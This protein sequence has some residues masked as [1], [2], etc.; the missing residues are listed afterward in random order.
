MRPISSL[1]H[2][3]RFVHC[4]LKLM[5]YLCK[6]LSSGPLWYPEHAPAIVFCVSLSGLWQVIAGSSYMHKCISFVGAKLSNR[7]LSSFDELEAVI[8]CD[9]VQI[10]NKIDA[11]WK[12]S[13][14]QASS[15]AHKDFIT[16][17]SHKVL[18]SRWQFSFHA[19]FAK[20][21]FYTSSCN[22]EPVVFQE[23]SSWRRQ[24]W[25]IVRL[26]WRPERPQPKP[27]LRALGALEP[28]LQL[29]LSNIVHYNCPWLSQHV[30]KIW[31]WFQI[32]IDIQSACYTTSQTLC[33]QSNVCTYMPH[34]K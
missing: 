26:W 29:A 5:P 8:Y 15:E 12:R 28:D 16:T 14:T 11:F 23:W 20:S 34:T 24:I 19:G 6:T 3:C 32:P 13:A 21:K 27:F 17:Q 31:M 9:S 25:V 7:G 30:C 18:N 10:E 4:S 2:A 33:K 22:S 1:R